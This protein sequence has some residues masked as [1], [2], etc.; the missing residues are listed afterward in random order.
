MTSVPRPRSPSLLFFALL[1]CVVAC[2]SVSRQSFWIDEVQ[3]ALKTLPPT[4]G[5]WW[6]A[7]DG[8]HTSNMQLPLYMLYI[9]G[10]ARVFGVSEIILRAGNIPWFFLG[11]FGIFYFLRRHAGLRSAALLLY[12][13]HPFVWYYLNEARPYIMQLSGALLVGG[14]LFALLD[15]PD[16]PPPPAWWWLL[17]AGLFILCGA[18]LLGVPWAVAY[19]IPMIRRAGFRQSITRTGRGAL[20]VFIPLLAL[21][22]AY[23][24]WTVKE[25]V[26]TGYLSMNVASML[27]V[28]YEQLGFLGLGPGRDALRAGSVSTLKPYLLPLF[29]LGL[30]LAC[31]LIFA[32]RRRFGLPPKLLAAILVIA[33]SPVCLIFALGFL[34]HARILGRHLTPLFPFILLAEAYALLVLWRSGR[35]L[36]RV[37]AVLI[38]AALLVSSLETRFGAR[39]AKDDY[40]EAA[41][42][43]AAA[44]EQGKTVWW[45]ASRD[46]AIYYNVPI[47]TEETAG[48]ALWTYGVPAQYSAPPD[49][50]F[51]TKSDLS[52]ARG[53]LA[54]F[55]A[56]R[57]YRLAGRW[58]AFTLW[59]KP[60]SPP[61]PGASGP[62]GNRPATPG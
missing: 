20:L 23:L 45:C 8:E 28:F 29:L 10:W 17:C 33:A 47:A 34:R 43:A 48:A 38:A 11:L 58:Q 55:I 37:A 49:E 2:V 59:E 15:E 52:D 60:A 46:G 4:L 25:N 57:G 54:A 41:A 1:A 35:V 39:H 36:G 3:T 16:Q 32:L 22:L 61:A 21:L 5:G 27:S 7:L 44:L 12:C 18:G 42:A 53:T 51:M 40:R 50:I 30:P 24:G 13:V 26:G 56:A 62:P 6:R 31:G 9:W 19:M 14:A